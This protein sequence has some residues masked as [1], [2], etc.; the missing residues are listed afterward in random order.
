MKIWFDFTNPPHVNFF[1]P[2]IAYYRDL[3]NEILCTAREFVETVELLHLHGIPFDLYG[4]HGGRK[5]IN[6]VRALLDRYLKLYRNVGDFD[7]SFSS[8]NEAPFISWLRRKPSYVFDDNDIAPNWLYSK[9]VNYVVSPVHIDKD[10][11][12]R[13]GVSRDKMIYYDGF[14]E[15]IYVADYVPDPEFMSQIPFRNFIT[16]RPENIQAAYVPHG[17][18]SIVPELIGKLTD[19]GINILYLPR[20]RADRD[21]IS[22]N[23][24]IFIPSKPLNGLD[25]SYYSDAVLTGAGSFS[26]EAAVIGT[27]SVSFFAGDKFLGVDKEMFRRQ[28]V[29]FSRDPDAIIQYLSKAK[30]K[31]FSPGASKAVQES[32]FDHL[33]RTL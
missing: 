12:Q 27:P 8:N 28:M 3:G 6:K 33:N 18:K 14:K 21:L 20:Y 29:F 4:K 2:V 11:M 19:K 15:N 13:M 31:E 10:A 1:K 17:V 30:K 25:V 32:L 5:K 22:M 24:R 26:R 16:V 23:D 9:F 7:V